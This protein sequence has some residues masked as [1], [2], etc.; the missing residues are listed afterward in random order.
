M[1]PLITKSKSVIIF[2]SYRYKI[3]AG[4]F[5]N[6]SY[7]ASGYLQNK[8]EVTTMYRNPLGFK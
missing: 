1:K 8:C 5:C 7:F 3:V 4:N 6:M 2:E